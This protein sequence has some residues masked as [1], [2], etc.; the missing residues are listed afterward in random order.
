MPENPDFSPIA[1]SY[2]RS[3]PGYPPELYA[4]LASQVG[5]RHLA[6]DVATG[7][8]QAA[9]DVAGHC[10]RVIATDVSAEQ[11]R[12]ARSHP[13]V[14]YRVAS[15]EASGLAAA[16]VDLVTVAAA[17]HWFD[18]PGFYR[19]VRRVGRAGAVVAAW[20][21]HVAHLAAPFDRVFAPFYFDLVAPYFSPAVRLVDDRYEGVELPGRPIAAPRFDMTA[22]WSLEQ[23]LA[24]ARTWSGVQAYE[25]ATGEDPVARLVPELE[26][27][28]GGS[29]AERAIRWPLY[30]KA[31]RL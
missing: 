31:S 1:A 7:S 27:I 18:L 11:I 9:V 20:T 2:A 26:A 25:A 3:R 13:R 16:S 19:E 14:E 22:R 4:W 10:E 12:H 23:L 29:T 28:Y 21:Y 15:A 30:L 6:W 8:G 24:F 5:P 17:L